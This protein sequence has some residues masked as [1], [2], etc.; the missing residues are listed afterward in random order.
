VTL[1]RN[2][3]FHVDLLIWDLDGT[4]ADTVQ[5]ITDSLN[6][7]VASFGLNPHTTDEVR[8]FI[9]GGIRNLIASAMGIAD[10]E[11]ERVTQAVADFRE[12]YGRNLLR[13]TRLYPGVREVLESLRSKRHVVISNK[14]QTMTRAII[15]GLGVGPLFREVIGQGGDYP[16]KPDPAS[17]LAMIAVHGSAPERAL[18]VG[19]SETD[20]QT[21]RNAGCHVVLVTYGLRPADQVRAL[22]ADACIDEIRPLPAL[23]A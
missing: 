14:M 15:E 11:D 18:F 6:R 22:G 19:D 2:G 23:I 21:A 4:L 7:I 9:G 10:Q 17:T 5:D 3:R 12:D 8:P 13:C 20:F 1:T 16:I